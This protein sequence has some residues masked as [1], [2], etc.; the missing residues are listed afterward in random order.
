VAIAHQ[1][2]T[3]SRSE[4]VLVSQHLTSKRY[5][6]LLAFVGKRGAD[7]S[8]VLPAFLALVAVAAAGDVGP[9]GLVGFLVRVILVGFGEF[10][11]GRSGEGTGGIHDAG[12]GGG[13]HAGATHSAP[14]TAT[15][16]G[17]DCYVRHLGGLR[18]EIRGAPFR[19]HDFLDDVL[20]VGPFFI[21]AR[22]ATRVVPSFLIQEVAA[23]VTCDVGAA[24]GHDIGRNA[25]I[26]YLATRIAGRGK[27]NHALPLE[28]L[29]IS[30]L[31]GGL[32]ALPTIGGLAAACRLYQLGRLVFRRQ[33]VG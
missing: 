1:T 13:R 22:P 32:P 31:A 8:A 10:S 33:Q 20:V 12:Q 6:R 27:V 25:G 4:R 29:V 7:T 24:R 2:R 28:V 15:V 26:T 11:I 17:V 14:A 21:H 3:R 30:G 23:S 18:R 19:A 16:F 9:V 5:E